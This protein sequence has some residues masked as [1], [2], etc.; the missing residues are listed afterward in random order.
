MFRLLRTGIFST[1][2]NDLGVPFLNLLFKLIPALSRSSHK[3]KGYSVK[4]L[5]NYMYKKSPIVSDAGV[6][7]KREQLLYWVER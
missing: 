6:F 7:V 5:I 1:G 2:L 3:V 4:S